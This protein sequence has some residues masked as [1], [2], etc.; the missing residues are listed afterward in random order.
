MHEKRLLE[1]IRD[2]EKDRG[3]TGEINRSVLLASVLSHLR[4][5]LNTKQGSVPIAEDYG[6]ADLT[7]MPGSFSPDNMEEIEQKMVKI[8]TKYDPRVADVRVKFSRKQ[9]DSLALRFEI[10]GRI[11][12]EGIPMP[13]VF[14]SIVEPSGKISIAS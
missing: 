4:R 11:N 2:Y 8:I 5:M 7:D 1:R 10:S 3:R 9:D 6:L 14:E 12:D 13:V